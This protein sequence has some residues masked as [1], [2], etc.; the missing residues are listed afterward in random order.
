MSDKDLLE[1][2]LRL[3]AEMDVHAMI[4]TQLVCKIASSV[5]QRGGYIAEIEQMTA[6]LILTMPLQDEKDRMMEISA[7]LHRTFR[8]TYDLPANLPRTGQ[9]ND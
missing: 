9:A 8:K 6:A 4:L 3:R 2:V 5:P 1:E 7:R